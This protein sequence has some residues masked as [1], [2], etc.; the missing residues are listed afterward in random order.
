ME[1]KTMKVGAQL[2]TVR[3]YTQTESDFKDTIEKIA[4]IGYETVQIS[5]IGR[6][7]KPEKVRQICDEAGLKIVLTHD[8]Y[9]AERILNDTE[10]LIEEHNI[11]GC[12]YIGLGGMPEKYRNAEWLY[13]FAKDFKEPAKKIAASGK[14]LMYHNHHFEFNKFAAEDAPDA[15]PD[16][17]IL[18][19]LMEWFTPEELGFTLDTYWVQAAG[20]DV[21][22]WVR[23]LKDRI[24]CV[25]LKD[26]EMV[27]NEAVMAPV[28]QG[29]LNF[30][31]IFK[32][33]EDSCCKYMLVEQDTCRTSPFDCLKVS[34]D[35]LVKAGYR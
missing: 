10:R 28:M 29:N 27:G 23:K 31:G 18:E 2:Y 20:A 14:L 12:D 33:L 13:H 16:K 24:P 3:T 32:E 22:E 5:G 21:C 19:Y 7:I 26:M 15:A 17:R 4:K 8:G 9:G 30:P 35:N 6:G 34:Y 1:E 25:H 11:L